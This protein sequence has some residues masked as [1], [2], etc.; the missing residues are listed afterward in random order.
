MLSLRLLT[1]DVVAQL[2]AFIADK[3]RWARDEFPHLVLTLAAK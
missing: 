3:N 2:D 1:N